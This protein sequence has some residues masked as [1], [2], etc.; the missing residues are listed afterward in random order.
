MGVK[1][2]V[3]IVPEELTAKHV[4]SYHRDYGNQCNARSRLSC[5]CVVLMVSTLDCFTNTIG[6]M[7]CLEGIMVESVVEEFILKAFSTH[8]THIALLEQSLCL[9]LWVGMISVVVVSPWTN[10]SWIVA[11]LLSLHR[12]PIGFLEWVFFFF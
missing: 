6:F 7:N 4:S 5:H 12:F 8:S 2:G 3:D 1:G 10:I 9:F 11:S